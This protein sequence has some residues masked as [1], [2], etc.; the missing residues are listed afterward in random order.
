MIR[1]FVYIG[2]SFLLGLIAFSIGWGEYTKPILIISIILI[3][4]LLLFLKKYRIYV[5]VCGFVFFFAIEYAELFTYFHYNEIMKFSNQEVVVRGYVEDYTYLNSDNGMLTIKGKIND[6]ETTMI[7]FWIPDDNYEYYDEVEIKGTVTA[8]KNSI[9]YHSKDNYRSKGIYLRGKK[10]DYVKNLDKNSHPLLKSIKE[11]RDYMFR[12]INDVVG[13]R[14]GAILSAMLCGDKSEMDISTRNI[15]YKIGLG[16]IF[17]VSGTHLLVIVNLFL[18]I[19]KF[20]HLSRKFRV[21]ITTI[22]IWLFVIFAG[23]SP[24][25]VRAGIMATLILLSQLLRRESDCLNTLGICCVILT[26]GNPYIV[27]NPSF[28][29]SMTGAFGMGVVAPHFTEMVKSQGFLGSILKSFIAIISM[30]FVSI[31]IFMLF[32]NQ[33]SIVGPLANLILVPICTIAIGITV[34][35]VITG[36]VDFIAIP[37]LKTAGVLIKFVIDISEK[38]VSFEYTSIVISQE[39]LK[40]II[41]CICLI[42]F[43]CL[44]LMKRTRMRILISIMVYISFICV[45]NIHRMIIKDEMHIVIFNDEKVS[46][47]L[48]YQSY[49]GVI[50]D[51]NAKGKH[52]YALQQF[53]EENNIF[54]IN[55]VIINFEPYY[56]QMQYKY[57]MIPTPNQIIGEFDDDECEKDEFLSNE[58]NFKFNGLNLNWCKEDYNINNDDINISINKNGFEFNGT[59]YKF[60]DEFIY[61]LVME[62][63][64]YKVRRLDYGINE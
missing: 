16:H 46:Q 13:G 47:T 6:R 24:S 45:Y 26:I 10:V 3:F 59:F 51:F 30:M 20:F 28:A 8:I 52:N 19:F 1:K 44:C 57:N 62:D 15:F 27:R 41:F 36:G 64:R 32:F 63:N 56:T 54:E 22:V 18:A 34:L 5:F 40:I 11:Y 37:I 49:Q 58:K 53:C 21:V 43:I 31:P 14:E 23:C 61:D 38:I 42:G 25:V 55:T 39:S 50:L 17:A 60:S 12:M 29:L 4:G 2:F 33:I 9:D 7:A 48:I 35:V